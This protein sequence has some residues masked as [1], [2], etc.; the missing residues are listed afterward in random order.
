MNDYDVI[1]SY[2]TGRMTGTDRAAFEASLRTDPALADDVAFYVMARQTAKVQANE[3]RR[4]EWDAR[5]RAAAV[6]IQPL[7][8]LGQWAYPLAAAACLVLALGFGWYFLNQPSASE[9]A[10]AYIN[11]NFATLSVTMDDRA[12]SLQTGIRQYN[13]GNLA[14]ADATFGTLLQRAPDNAD[15]LKMAGIVSLRR[16]K[17]DQA[18]A[19]FHRLSQR[20]DLYANP[21]LF[22]EAV[23]RLKRNQPLDKPTAKTLLTTVINSNLDCRDEAGKLLERL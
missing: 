15:A 11:Q 4:A 5:R 10:D 3:Q 19:Q 13:E 14:G 1:E 21:G 12:D 23:A 18:I 20:T 6:P 9:L 8:Q 16:E 17:Y 22:Y 7:R 2:L